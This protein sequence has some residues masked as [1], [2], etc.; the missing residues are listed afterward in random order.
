MSY[1][2]HFDRLGNPVY[3]PTKP[4]LQHRIIRWAS[5]T[6]VVICLGILLWGR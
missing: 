1:H 4:S 3:Q 2:Q 6:T 5:V